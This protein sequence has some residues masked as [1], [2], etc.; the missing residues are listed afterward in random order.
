MT[1]IRLSR[2]ACRNKREKAAD[3]LFSLEGFESFD[4]LYT[5]FTGPARNL[6]PDAG[7][8]GRRRRRRVVITRTNTP[9]PRRRYGQAA[10]VATLRARE[11][12]PLAKPTTPDRRRPGT[13]RTLYPV[14]HRRRTG[15]VQAAR[16]ERRLWSS[17]SS[18]S[19]FTRQL[20][21]PPLPSAPASPLP[22]GP[23]MR[24]H[25]R[26]RYVRSVAVP[27]RSV[28]AATAYTPLATTLPSSVQ[29]VLPRRRVVRCLV[30]VPRYLV[31]VQNRRPEIIFLLISYSIFLS[32]CPFIH[33]SLRI[34]I[35]F[36]TFFLTSYTDLYTNASAVP[37]YL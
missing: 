15:G 19:S 10:L 27:C 25:A 4:G 32:L 13:R 30:H 8:R 12:T 33:Y 14:Q 17:S 5:R 26:A 34:N 23:A 1:V 35:I 3:S 24:A 37:I 9:S 7:D 28:A 29:S 31:R 36:S 6:D 16:R 2:D 11:K 18:S 20:L 22:Y 21:P